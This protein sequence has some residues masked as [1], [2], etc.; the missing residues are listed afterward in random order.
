MKPTEQAQHAWEPAPRLVNGSATAGYRPRTGL[1][2]PDYEGW[3]LFLYWKMLKPWC[4]AIVAATVALVIATFVLT[5]LVLPRW[6]EATAL[7]RPASQELPAFQQSG[8]SATGFNTM[9]SSLGASL[10]FSGGAAD[11]KEQLAI[12]N[13]YDFTVALIHG[14]RL[15]SRLIRK[16]RD[17]AWLKV[18]SV[19]NLLWQV[20]PNPD[21]RLYRTMS[22]RFRAGYNESS[23]NL[24]LTLLDRDP[25]MARTIL[26]YYVDGLR[27]KLKL[28]VVKSSEAA[29]K[30]LEDEVARAADPMLRAQLDQVLATQIQQGAT[31]EV[32]ADFAFTVIEA[33]IVPEAFSRPRVWLDCL[34]AA[35]F[36]PLLLVAWIVIHGRMRSSYRAF[37][38]WEVFIEAEAE[39][40]SSDRPESQSWRGKTTMS[41]GPAHP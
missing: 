9:A 20:Q 27:D 40:S 34:A 38:N 33:P 23:G 32:Q 10:G 37:R 18:S 30:A 22:R 6:Y 1:N 15:E 11:A 3:E 8:I 2:A 19:T 26:G 25:A 29:V 16:S 39:G 28:R 41:D 13:S 12:L 35:F 14:H 7:I 5:A 36:T 21:W 17:G 24:Q 31:A 4:R